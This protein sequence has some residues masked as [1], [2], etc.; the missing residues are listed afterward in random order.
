[1]ADTDALLC[2]QAPTKKELKETQ[3]DKQRIIADK[4]VQIARTELTKHT[5]EQL[6]QTIQ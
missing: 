4:K 2:F 5:V 1:V 6:F 3:I